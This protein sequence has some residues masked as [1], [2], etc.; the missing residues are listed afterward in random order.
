[1]VDVAGGQGALLSSS[2]L[3]NPEQRGILFD[4]PAVIAG[5]REGIERAGLAGR[6][7][8]VGGS[9]FE[10][11]P[12]GADGYMMKHILHDWNDDDAVAILKNV[13]RAA[14]PGAK[15]FVIDAVI[16]PGN[17][18]GFAKLMDLEMLVLYNGGRERTEAELGALFDASGFSLTRVVPTNSPA[19]VVE[20]VRI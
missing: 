11:I 14:A 9:F 12:E 20:A 8:L 2:L 15:L 5:A 19:A 10:A 3:R 16:E 13:H 6:C 17:E 7:E 18:P 1:L 4:Q